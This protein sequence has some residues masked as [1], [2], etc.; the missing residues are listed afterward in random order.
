MSLLDAADEVDLLERGARRMG[1][2]GRLEGGP[3]LRPDHAFAQTRNVGVGALMDA[4]QVVGDDIASR[5][6]VDADHPGEIIV[7]VDQRRAL[8]DI[9]RHRESI[10]RGRGSVGHCAAPF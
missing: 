9:A 2:V 4:G 5:R 3:E 7:P 6:A 8:E 1:R 10:V